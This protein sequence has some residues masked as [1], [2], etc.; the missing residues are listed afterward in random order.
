MT[1][2]HPDKDRTD[3]PAD[4]DRTSGPADPAE[5]PIAEPLRPDGATAGRPSVERSPVN[6]L[7]PV[8][9]V[10]AGPCKARVGLVVG[11]AAAL[12]VGAVTTSIAASPA[13]AATTASNP[14]P[15]STG[16]GGTPLVFAVEPALDG[17]SG[18]HDTGRFGG[19]G[20]FRDITISAIS[21][22]N[23]TLTT[24]DG[25]TRTVAVTDSV[26][27]TKGGQDIALSD[28][29]VGDQVRLGQ[30]RNDDGSY[31]VTEIAVVVPRV[32]G[33]VSDLTGSSFKVTTRDGSVWTITT[34]EATTYH[35]GLADGTRADLADGATVLVQGTSTRATTR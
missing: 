33:T 9:P 19:P 16:S 22:S 21:G 35:F 27:L 29:A 6:P 3:R 8:A 31:P 11:A 13:P 10:A 23:V 12:A 17:G 1:T 20:G 25:W 28:L 4:P 26:E 30:V 5:L 32:S 18:A 14:G 15:I 7:P 34:N 24:A 2:Y